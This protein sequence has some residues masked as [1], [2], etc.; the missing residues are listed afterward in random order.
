MNGMGNERRDLL[1]QRG[2][3]GVREEARHLGLGKPKSSPKFEV[4][5]PRQDTDRWRQLRG[6]RLM[7]G[8]T[9]GKPATP[10]QPQG[11]EVGRPSF[12]LEQLPA[13]YTNKWAII[14]EQE[15]VETT[16][17]WKYPVLW[18]GAS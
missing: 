4:R 3:R 8:G 10:T 5:Q 13:T 7:G 18:V 9:Q 15:L 1:K 12:D 16:C 14:R 11:G 6:R 17:Q 2:W